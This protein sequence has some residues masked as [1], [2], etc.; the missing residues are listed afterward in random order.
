MVLALIHV[1]GQLVLMRATVIATTD[2]A[3]SREM[4]DTAWSREWCRSEGQ[5]FFQSW[6]L[7]DWLRCSGQLLELPSSSAERVPADD[8]LAVRLGDVGLPTPTPRRR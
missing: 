6:L 7:S 2:T 5:W 3:W 1:H 8:M 4:T